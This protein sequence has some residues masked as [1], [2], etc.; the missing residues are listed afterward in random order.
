[1]IAKIWAIRV[2]LVLL[3]SQDLSIVYSDFA[4]LHWYTLQTRETSLHSFACV[5]RSLFLL[6]VLLRP[7]SR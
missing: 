3:R 5:S 4:S 6:R 2:L 7:C 1:M